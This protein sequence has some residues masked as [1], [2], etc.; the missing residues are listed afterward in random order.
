MTSAPMRKDAARNRQRIV[1]VAR[2]L[3]DDGTP[4]QLN[5]VARLTGV[6]VATV[7][8]HFPTPEALM[9]TVAAPGLEALVGHA[10]RA[11]TED[12][13]WAALAGFLDVTLEAQL[14]DPSL[15]IVRAAPARVLPRTEELTATLDSLAG[16]LLD[17][18]RAAGAVRTAVTWDDLLPLMCGIA[19]AAGIHADDRQARLE[20]GRRYLGVMLRGLRG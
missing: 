3:V 10:E 8:R 6:G 5:D 13:P 7:Y 15:T 1:D 12:D 16:R 20:S 17:R 9:E 11:L 14:T 4:L 2:R 19:F 18:T